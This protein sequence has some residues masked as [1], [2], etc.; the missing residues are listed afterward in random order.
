M[1]RGISL[2]V[3]IGERGGGRRGSLVAR[4]LSPLTT[5]HP[6][7]RPPMQAAHHRALRPR[8]GGDAQHLGRA[9]RLRA[10]LPG[11]ARCDGDRPRR[12]P[13]RRRRQRRRGRGGGSTR[14]A[15]AAAAAGAAARGLCRGPA[16][17]RG[18]RRRAARLPGG[19]AAAGGRGGRLGP[20]RQPGAFAR[21]ARLCCLRC[22]SA[23]AL[24]VLDHQHHHLA[25]CLS[26]PATDH[27]QQYN[28]INNKQPPNSS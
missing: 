3:Q 6:P 15:A 4:C 23:F 22:C 26:P 21:G 27:H 5:T 7:V 17:A 9:P 10:A 20:R 19:A 14:A 16:R 13:G 8:V 12:R 25:A 28:I 1:G 18:G 24:C 11:A 2:G